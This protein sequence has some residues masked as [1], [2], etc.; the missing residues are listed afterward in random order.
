MPNSAEVYRQNALLE[1]RKEL[2]AKLA[3]QHVQKEGE[4]PMYRILFLLLVFSSGNAESFNLGNLLISNI[5]D[6]RY[7]FR[8][9]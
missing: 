7:F 3:A 9:L 6:S 5:M 4:V 8:I 2:N 1:H